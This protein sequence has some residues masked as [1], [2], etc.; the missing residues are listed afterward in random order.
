[1]EKKR[2]EDNDEFRC[3]E[4]GYIFSSFYAEYRRQFAQW[5]GMFREVTSSSLR[6]PNVPLYWGCTFWVEGLVEP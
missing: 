4:C 3:G 6:E 1:M 2:E 5:L